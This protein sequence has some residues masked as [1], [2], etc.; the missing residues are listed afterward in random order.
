MTVKDSREF[1]QHL[2]LQTNFTIDVSESPEPTSP[3]KEEEDEEGFQ[4]LLRRRCDRD[5]KLS[6]PKRRTCHSPNGCGKIFCYL[7]YPD[8][9]ATVS[10]FTTSKRLRTAKE[11]KLTPDRIPQDTAP[12]TTYM[13]LNPDLNPLYLNIV[14]LGFIWSQLESGS[15]LCN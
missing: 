3:P 10:P 15:F 11:S 12:L 13:D 7:C 6:T 14:S 4:A 8:G 9:D 1:K 5:A 2:V